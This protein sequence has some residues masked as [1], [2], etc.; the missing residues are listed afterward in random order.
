MQAVLGLVVLVL[1]LFGAGSAGA[2]DD[3]Y[4]GKRIRLI[5]SSSPG[6]GNDTYSRL[7]ARHIGRHI[8]GNPSLIVQNMPGAGGLVAAD[9]LYNKAKRD[10]TVMEQINWGVWNWQ[11]IGA[12]RARFD[13][14]K[15]NAIGVAAIENCLFYARADRFKTLADI[16]KSGRLATVG[17]SGPQS[18]GYVVGNILEELTGDKM[19]D[20]LTSYPGARQY[21]LALRQGEVDAAGNTHSSFFDQLGDMFKAGGIVIL[22]QTGDVQGN[23]SPEFANAPL[24]E[25]MAKTPK[26]KALVKATF[27][28]SRYG[29]P[30]SM[31]PNVP[32]DRVEVVRAAF[33]K[34]MNDPKFL[35]EAKKLKRPVLPATGAELQ[36]MWKDSLAASPEDVATIKKI[37]GP[38]AK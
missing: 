2:A 27:L 18:T 10:G 31:P 17:A 35:A 38:G 29:R 25:D 30:Y 28:L 11:V 24:I 23:K 9:Y 36:K 22:A 6:G 33:T 8:P 7:I 13:F 12:K 34:T 32:K 5:V 14:D 4:K 1:F 3:F 20:Y 26:Q 16:K 19:F 21:S 37:F 15:L